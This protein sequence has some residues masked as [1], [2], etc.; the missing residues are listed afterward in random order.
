MRLSKENVI[1]R[2][3]SHVLVSDKPDGPYVPMEDPTY[4]PA[5]KPTLDGTFWVD[6][7]GKPYM[8]YSHE[9]LQ[10]WNGTMERIELKPDLS[11]TVGQKQM[12]FF[13]SNSSWSPAVRR[14]S[15]C[16]QKRPCCSTRAYGFQQHA[17]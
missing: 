9:W 16:T 11:G 13:A 2:R 10:N 8:I 17:T 4:L 12:L 3:A 15:Q 7:D 6:T 14:Y 5:D 1:N